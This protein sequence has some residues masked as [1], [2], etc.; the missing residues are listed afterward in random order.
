MFD[1]AGTLLLWD[2]GIGRIRVVLF[3]R[4]DTRSVLY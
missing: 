1:Q 4:T 2:S 3:R